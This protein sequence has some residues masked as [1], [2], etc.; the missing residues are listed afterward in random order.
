[1]SLPDVALDVETILSL[2]PIDDPLLLDWPKR[3][4][5]RELGWIPTFDLDRTDPHGLYGGHVIAQ[6]V[7]AACQTVSDGFDVHSTHGYFLRPGNSQERI[8]YNV[9][10]V[11]TGR[12][13]ATRRIEAVQFD[14]VIYTS[15]AN[16]KR[17]FA[18]QTREEDSSI[19]H[20]MPYP[21]DAWFPK[22][23]DIAK[24]PRIPDVDLPGLHG[25]K[26]HWKMPVN[27]RKFPMD[28]I[29]AEIADVHKRRQV[30]F[31]RSR[32]A[33]TNETHNFRAVVLMYASDRNFLFTST[34]AHLATTELGYGHVASLDHSFVLH[35]SL[36]VTSSPTST[37]AARY[38][39]NRT[40][41]PRRIK[42]ADDEAEWLTYDTHSPAAG[43]SRCLVTGYM[44]N[45]AGEHL[46][47]VTQE[48]L[49]DVTVIGPQPTR[50]KEET[51]KAGRAGG[52]GGDK[53]FT[54]DSRLKKKY[55]SK[56]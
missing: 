42:A 52:G 47:T 27:Y 17:D 48:A 1:M 2:D 56:L 34:N 36:G 28:E 29:N 9:F 21:T 33:I 14:K 39:A 16:F 23:A 19:R 13:Y 6:T 18:I 54:K 51:V 43:N 5:A 8:V 10:E 32:Y 20:G 37:A 35:R 44:W 41:R 26:S 15:F 24:I 53:G 49:A 3:F 22:Y 50:K 31:F 11:R 38:Q 7:W 46:A 25:F 45:K 55:G 12:N 30:H 4:I 40:T